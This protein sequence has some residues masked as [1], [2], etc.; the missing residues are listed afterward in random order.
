MLGWVFN[1][2]QLRSFLAHGSEMKP[3]TAILLMLLSLAALA[4][5]FK[6]SPAVIRKL[7]HVF[8]FTAASVAALTLL[9]YLTQAN[10]G[11]DELLFR[12]I[13]NA[14]GTSHP[15]RMSV[16]T[17]WDFLFGTAALF[18]LDFETRKGTRP[19]QWLALLMA[20][21]PTQILVCYIYGN[22]N[23]LAF[24]SRLSYM[25]VPTASALLAIS[26]ALLLHAPDRGLM[27]TLT[28]RNQAGRMFRRLILGLLLLPPVLGWLVLEFFQ[29]R[30]NPPEFGISATVILSIL[31]LGALAWFSAAQ[32]NRSLEATRATEAAKLAIFESAL[33]C[34]ITMDQAGRITEFSPMAEKTF[35]WERRE[36]LG[37]TVG[38]TIVPP[39]F[40]EAHEQGLARFLKTGTG[41]VMG[42]RVEMT[43]L[44][45]DCTRFPVELAIAVTRVEGAAPF[46]TAYLRDISERKKSEQSLAERARLLNLTLDAIMVLDPA[47]RILFWNDGAEEM[48]GWSA[49]YAIGKLVPELLFTEFPVP[50][51][52]LHKILVRDGRW[53]G[54]LRQRR[55]DGSHLT[56]L[57]RWSLDRDAQGKPAFILETDTDITAKK[58]AEEALRQSES[59]LRT[60]TNEARVGLVLVN[61]HRRYLF[62]NA[63]YAQI[64]SLPGADIVGQRV[65]D[66][67]APVYDQ[68]GPRLDRAFAGERVTYELR[69]PAKPPSGQE[70]IYE[71]IYEPRLTNPTEPYVVVVIVDITQ[72]KRAED[73][74]A[75]SRDELERVVQERTSQ[76]REANANLQAFT[77]TAAHDLRAPL[78][79]IKNF[80]A[81]VI[82]DYA[83]QL[84]PEGQ[85]ALQR[86]GQSAEQMDHLLAGLLEYSAMTQAELRPEPV[87]FRKVLF[88][89]LTLLESDI[90]AKSASVK[91]EDSPHTV[92]AHPATTIAITANL[93]SNALKFIP[94]GVQ[95]QIRIWTAEAGEPHLK[96]ANGQASALGTGAPTP[97]Q[98][99]RPRF[100]RLNVQDNGIGIESQYLE[101][102][103][104]VFERLHGKEDYAGSGLGLAIVKKGAE[105]MGGRVGV[106]SE[107]GKGSKFWIELPK[108]TEP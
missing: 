53:S 40:R 35:G 81:I 87:E 83:S 9:E 6:Q 46:F 90:T 78:R 38:E 65:A 63:T 42:K 37:K 103:F 56:V 67:L 93:I 91:V 31:I 8:A 77:Y 4:R 89:A 7:A 22:M 66:V 102:I 20:A 86:I 72:R 23:V 59:L 61:Q 14:I 26:L 34:I 84:D 69:M 68:I 64:L 96:A 18:L 15:G 99:G 97:A 28:T 55:K 101:K 94:S 80:S 13:P 75:R 2:P 57:T 27:R 107:L 52:E 17:A 36:V 79:S 19:S 39:E 25:A 60:V 104:G 5:S 108:T 1:L 88:D 32:L 73:V 106:E 33:D 16:P 12:D 24:G 71:V 95:P 11:I 47:N 49:A 82:E 30:E 58:R 98:A 62:A 105:R 21:V 50:P 45:S 100:V 70:T 41:P 10:L 3:N 51:D 74:L 43:A 92:S 76:L 44:R 29:G 54:E 48:Y 85:S